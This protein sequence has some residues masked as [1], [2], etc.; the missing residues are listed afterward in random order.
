MP[1]M[2]SASSTERWMLVTVFSRSTTTPRRRPSLGALPTPTTRSSPEEFWSA[3]MQ[4]ILVV[5][6]SRPTNVRVAWAMGFP[7]AWLPALA[8]DVPATPAG[9]AGR[10]LP[11]VANDDL[12]R[13]PHVDL[14][15]RHAL[16]LEVGQ[17]RPQTGQ[18]SRV[19]RPGRSDHAHAVHEH[20]ARH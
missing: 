4:L 15:G 14:P 1:A 20:Q 2:R 7:P 9:R 8:S 3:M 10:G 6:M 17:R 13:N 11:R 5:P 12:L 19:R 18:L 16:A